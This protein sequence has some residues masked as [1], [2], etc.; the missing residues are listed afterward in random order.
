MDTN[1]Q[2]RIKVSACEMPH[3]SHKGCMCLPILAPRGPSSSAV[4][5]ICLENNKVRIGK[6]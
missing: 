2:R 6:R 4:R 5:E 1:F 3:I